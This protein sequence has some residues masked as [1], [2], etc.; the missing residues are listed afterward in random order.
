MGKSE[1][2]FQSDCIKYLKEHR[3]Y[4]INQFGSGFGGKGTADLTTCINGIFVVFELKV[5]GNDMSSAQ[6]IHKRRIERNGGLHFKPYTLDEFI[7]NVKYVQEH[8]R[9]TKV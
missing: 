3:I 6:R 8:Y 5:D 9:K 7:E 4:Y 1:S 2:S